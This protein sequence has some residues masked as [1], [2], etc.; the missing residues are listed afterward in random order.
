MGSPNIPKARLPPRS[1][2]STPTA[3]TSLS[4]SPRPALPVSSATA[5]RASTTRGS[6]VA[7]CRRCRKPRAAATTARAPWFRLPRR[8]CPVR[9]A[10]TVGA[11]WSKGRRSRG[12]LVRRSAARPSASVCASTASG[13]P[14][15]SGGPRDERSIRITD[16]S[17]RRCG[18]LPRDRL[19]CACAGGRRSHWGGESDLDRHQPPAR[20]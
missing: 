14:R 1:R 9:P 10:S 20:R 2:E 7:S 5:W 3:P 8:R 13:E 15:P 11:T 4:S 19:G 6:A 18:C 16:R 17:L 12:G